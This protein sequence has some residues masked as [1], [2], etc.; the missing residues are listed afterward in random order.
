MGSETVTANWRFIA[1]R[2][3]PRR[4]ERPP[5]VSESSTANLCFEAAVSLGHRC[6][7]WL[8]DRVL[9]LRLEIW[10]FVRALQVCPEFFVRVG[11]DK[12]EER[13]YP[14]RLDRGRSGIK[15]NAMLFLIQIDEPL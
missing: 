8:S 4:G 15:A 1:Q 13:E 5:L 9:V 7:R 12:A 11:C 14:P 2:A 6:P 10:L 3:G